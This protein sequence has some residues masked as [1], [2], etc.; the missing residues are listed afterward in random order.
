MLL[1][2]TELRYLMTE[3]GF[4]CKGGG[5]CGNNSSDC[6]SYD[7]IEYILHYDLMDINTDIRLEV[8]E[9]NINHVFSKVKFKKVIPYLKYLTITPKK[10]F[11]SI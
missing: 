7:D 11:E 8:K 10:L 6:Y 1:T 5:G 4:K 2:G 3:Q 9:K